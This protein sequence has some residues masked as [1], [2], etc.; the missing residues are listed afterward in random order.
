[1]LI[2][3]DIGTSGAKAILMREDGTILSSRREEYGISAPRPGWAEQRPEMWFEKA[4]ACLRAVAAERPGEVKGIAFS[5]QMHGIVLVDAGGTPVRDAII[6]ADARSGAEVE[7]ITA[8]IGPDRLCATTLN[9]VAAGF[10]LASLVWL[11]NH[12]PHSLEQAACMLCPKDYVRF[13]LGGEMVQEAS[14]ASATCCMD[15]RRGEWAWDILDALRLPAGIFPR[16][17]TAADLAGRLTAEAAELCGL[18]IGT[19]L[20]CGGA[21]NCMAGIGAGLIG[22]GW[23]GANIGT[24]GQ[25]GAV[26]SRPVF[27]REF[28]T[29]TFCHPLPGRW[30]IF[31]ATLAAGLALRWFR[32]AF[33][34]ERS[35]ADLSEL[36]A[37]AEPGAGGLLF[38]PYLAGERTPWLD[39]AARGV[40][41]GLS[42]RHGAAEMCRAV[43]E[44]VTF[45]LNQSFELIVG[46]GVAA[47]RVLAMGGG[48]ASSLW[49][50]IQ[51]DMFGLPV[52]VAE[53]GDACVGAAIV[54]GV[55]AGTYRDIPQ[56]VVA[57][58][59]QN[60][61]I[62]EPDAGNHL[63]Y[64]ER[65]EVFR[66]L[67]LSTR[68]LFRKDADRKGV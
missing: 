20:Y 19:P 64:Q 12:E 42:L 33:F 23:L 16:I 32:D 57:A 30:T 7:A 40:F 68:D 21:D 67:Y 28:R 45:A 58:V 39:P 52:Q 35:F 5:G 38:L 25:V 63:L 15:V 47:E 54:A 22:E 43:M 3:V 34:P 46:A 49:P 50:Q 53:G 29:S 27:D 65:K 37:R 41:W 4:T 6:W 1:M 44:G 17:G 24:G 51:A 10:G 31:G 9:R 60:G 61:R 48:A 8:A 66:D 62:F 2:G 59:R 55:G 13:R 11:R 18:P 26:A 14:D 36:A 56:G